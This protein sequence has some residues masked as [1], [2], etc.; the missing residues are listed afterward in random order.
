MSTTQREL[1]TLRFTGA[2][3]ERHGLDLDVLPELIAYKELIVATAKELWRATHPG[4]ERLPRGFEEAI[5][6]SMSDVRQGSLVIP[7]T[8]DVDVPDIPFLIQEPDEIEQAVSVL[9][10]AMSAA[11]SDQLLPGGFPVAVLP[12][13]EDFGRTLRPDELITLVAPGRPEPVVY[14]AA[15]RDRLAHWTEPVY[16]D[17]AIVSGEVRA[18]D[19]D[20]GSFV[21]RLDTGQKVPARFS[22]EHEAQVTSALQEHTTRRLRARGRGEYLQS[23]GAL[24]KLL[25]VDELVLFPLGQP[26][27]FDPDASPIWERVLALGAAVPAGEWE[28][29]APHFAE[30]LDERLYGPKAR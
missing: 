2:R 9:D 7:L 13:F 11:A 25:Q 23:T 21:L 8:R 12:L 15:V 22:L 29:V 10:D 20:G 1:T 24:R 16:Q 4:R 5:R 17:D 19:L 14:S 27:A 6:I 30:R 28:K 26:D 18:A 3:F